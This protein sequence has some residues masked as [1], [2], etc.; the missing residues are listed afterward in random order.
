MKT[1]KIILIFFVILLIN[2][3]LL[4]QEKIAPIQ[5]DRPDLT[6]SP[7]LTPTHFLQFES[8]CL[9]ENFDRELKILTT[10]TLLS[11]YGINQMF[12]VRLITEIVSVKTNS[13]ITGLPPIW[14][15]FKS[16]IMKEHGF[17]PEMAFIGHLALAK[18]SSE[19]LRTN[20]AAPQFRFVMQNSLSKNVSLGYNVG[21]EWDGFNESPSKIYTI[22]TG[23]SLG[24]RLGFFFE[25]FGNKTKFE[26]ANHSFDAG[27]TYLLNPNSMLDFSAGLALKSSF[28]YQFFSCGYSCR[29]DVKK[30]HF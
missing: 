1:K 8:G 27:M 10:P 24:K 19:R 17:F 2:I 29:M 4:A 23:V 26:N 21:M 15:G 12:E 25:L 18:L 20:A 28:K 9:Y 16:K 13:T 30:R 11:K 7:F 22:T 14:I 6:E 3:P 5:L